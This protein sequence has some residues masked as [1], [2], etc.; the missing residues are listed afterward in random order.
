M[1]SAARPGK[2]SGKARHD[3]RR[4]IDALLAE[5][6]VNRTRPISADIWLTEARHFAEF[7]AA[8]GD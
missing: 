2:S 1:F 4:R 3:A 8:W 5:T 7:N 6:G